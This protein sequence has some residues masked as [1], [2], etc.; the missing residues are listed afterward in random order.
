LALGAAGLLF[1]AIKDYR[2][3]RMGLLFCVIYFLAIGTAHRGFPRY[4]T[5][6]LPV[7]Y[8]YA[9]GFVVKCWS[10]AGAGR[11]RC[12][13][14]LL[15]LIVLA[16]MV[17]IG[18]K[19]VRNHGLLQQPDAYS[20]SYWLARGVHPAKVLVAGFAPSVELEAA[21][22]P[23][24]Q[25]S[26]ASLNTKT[27]GATLSCDEL[28]IFDQKNARQHSVSAAGDSSV[29]ELLSDHSVS[30]LEDSGQVVLQKTG[31]PAL[32]ARTVRP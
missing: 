24:T 13:R 23:A 30:I 25:V 6:F 18:H 20:R 8:V 28:L 27:L 3:H 22:I 19:L 11:L 32:P 2:N 29:R 21:G 15:A 16:G 9:A 4:L 1:F 14:A 12:A 10:E 31:C 5:P 7:V 26:W 17:Q